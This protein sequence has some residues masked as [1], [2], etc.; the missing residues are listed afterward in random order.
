VIISPKELNS[1]TVQTT[2][3]GHYDVYVERL[4]SRE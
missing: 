1:G 2:K 4:E 3:S